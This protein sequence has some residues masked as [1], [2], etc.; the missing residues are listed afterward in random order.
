[1][2]DGTLTAS[3]TESTQG[4]GPAEEG[5]GVQ[6]SGDPNIGG[7]EGARGI[8]PLRRHMQVGGLKLHVAGS[9]QGTCRY[10]GKFKV[11][12]ALS[13]CLIFLMQ[14]LCLDPTPRAFCSTRR[15]P[16]EARCESQSIPWKESQHSSNSLPIHT[17]SSLCSQPHPHAIS[18]CQRRLN[19]SSWT[20]RRYGHG[21]QWSLSAGRGRGGPSSGGDLCGP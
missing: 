14:P 9:G 11:M 6:G 16:H 21:G 10:S 4:L 17:P 7:C 2:F 1:M 19:P 13:F 15:E 12:V 5:M 8:L 3:A 18:T 20:H